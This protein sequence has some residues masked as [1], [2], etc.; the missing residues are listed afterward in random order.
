MGRGS[1][2]VRAE[3]ASVLMQSKRYAEAEREYRALLAGDPSNFNCLGLARALAWGDRRAR[4]SRASHAPATETAG[5][6]HRD[7]AAIGARGDDPDVSEARAWV[8]EGRTM[9]HTVSH[10][11]CLHE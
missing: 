3:L 4:R 9:H 10:C 7:A 11:A 6:I 8:R 2:S 1:T 5:R